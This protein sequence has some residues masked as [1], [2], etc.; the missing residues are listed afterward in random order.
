MSQPTVFISYSHKDEIWKDRLRPH[1]KVL[2]QQGQI[3]IWKEEIPYLLERR[4]NDGMTLTPVL[5]RACAWKAVSWLKQLQMLPRDGKTQ[6]TI[7]KI[8]GTKF[9]LKWQSLF[10]KSLKQTKLQ[11][12]ALARGRLPFGIR[13]LASGHG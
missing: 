2:E 1:L 13:P 3:T 11:R 8:I 9:L 4:K 5:V 7:S 12:R 6:Q 10:S